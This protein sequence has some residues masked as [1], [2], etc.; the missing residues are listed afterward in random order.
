MSLWRSRMN[1]VLEAERSSADSDKLGVVLKQETQA[2][3][4][5]AKHK[6]LS[7]F[8]DDIF[9]SFRM[10]GKIFS[11]EFSDYNWSDLGWIL[12]GL[13]YLLLPF[14]AIPDFV[15]AVGFVDDAGAL[16]VAFTKSR[17]LLSSFQNFLKMGKAR[18]IDRILKNTGLGD[19]VVETWKRHSSDKVIK[20][21]PAGTPLLVSL[22]GVLEHSGIYLGGGEVAELFD[23]DKEGG[24]LRKVSLQKFL[25][26]DG[27]IRTGER[28]YA[29]CR[30]ESSDS[31]VPLSEARVDQC[32]REFLG[33]SKVAYN[34]LRSNCHMFTASCCLERKL[35]VE[36]D[37]KESL[38]A[39]VLKNL[40]S[41]AAAIAVGT[42]SV[43]KLM[44][45]I[46]KELNSGRDVYWCPVDRWS[47]EFLLDPKE[48]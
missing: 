31:F 19:S 23:D 40:A 9:D 7:S 15:P 13:G 46:A 2:V 21:P 10:L 30:K 18:A 24:Q 41:A 45:V 16:G 11:G 47:R 39:A 48:G 34:M 27:R 29:A 37:D 1:E 22:A 4:L 44:K 8:K 36:R 20:A 14:D 25:R 33:A 3:E 42:F 5:V 43:E 28:I 12:G 26:G 6:R 35:Y 17:P 32:A 38:G